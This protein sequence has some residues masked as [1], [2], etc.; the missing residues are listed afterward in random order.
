MLYYAAYKFFLKLFTI[1]K[2]FCNL[3]SSCKLSVNGYFQKVMQL[4]NWGFLGASSQF[5]QFS[6]SCNLLDECCHLISRNCL[7]TVLVK[8]SEHLFEIF[9]WYFA[10]CSL[11]FTE[12][13][14]HKC[15]RLS[16]VESITTV[17]VVL[18]PDLLDASCDNSVNINVSHA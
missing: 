16:F 2:D 15:S 11:H 4:L 18:I 9:I 1:T 6:E 13:C 5:I 8:L 17:L 10:T 3:N 12:S 7:V 14:L